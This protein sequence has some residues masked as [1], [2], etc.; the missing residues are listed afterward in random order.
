MNKNNL[1]QFAPGV[2]WALVIFIVSS[3]P[4][5]PT[6]NIGITFSDKLAHL[7]VFAVLGF[8]IAWPFCRIYRNYTK[9][10]WISW[11]LS[12]FYGILDEIHQLFVP[13]RYVEV[14]DMLADVIGA[15]IG[16][17]LF[18]LIDKKKSTNM[19]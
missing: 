1:K 2:A 11:I 4:E 18:L 16:V 12:G 7:A 10:F 15:L 13:G 6:T 8:L 5:L 19:K 9:A 3:I 14:L 17:G